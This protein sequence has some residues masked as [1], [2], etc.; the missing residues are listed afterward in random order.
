M[1]TI[2]RGRSC[3]QHATCTYRPA[4]SLGAAGVT[5][6]SSRLARMEE[7]RDAGGGD[8][9]SRVYE[10]DRPELFLKVPL[11]ESKD[12]MKLFEFERFRLGCTRTRNNPSHKSQRQHSRIHHR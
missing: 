7:S 9:Y 5:Y 2:S 1:Q 3:C 8:F 11:L 12:L 6:F 10:A 4:R